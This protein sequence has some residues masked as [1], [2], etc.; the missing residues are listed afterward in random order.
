[1][2]S[3]RPSL[4][5]PVKTTFDYMQWTLFEQFHWKKWLIWGFLAFLG[6]NAGRSGGFSVPGRYMAGGDD[7]GGPGWDKVQEW[8]VEH[9][10]TLV[11]IGAVAGIVILL[12]GLAWLYIS[13]R[14]RF[15]FLECLIE[16][17]TAIAESWRNN[18][19]LALS[20]FWWFLGYAVFGLL[21]L[22]L[23][24]ISVF[25]AIFRDGHFL[26][27]GEI[28]PK[29]LLVGAGSI[30]IL[31]PIVVIAIYLDDF[32]VPLMWHRRLPVLAAWGVFLDHFRAQPVFFLLY[33]PC[34]WVFSMAAGMI[35][36]LG[37]CLTCCLGA[38]PILGHT[39]FLPVFAFIRM[40]P[41]FV[42][43]QFEPGLQ[44][45]V[46]RPETVSPQPAPN[47]PSGGIPPAPDPAGPEPASPIGG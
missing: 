38:I 7:T 43:G 22:A 19:R 16:N 33:V 42:L 30:L 11:V 25:L 37:M 12:L 3:R 36:L 17:K 2:D 21:L 20:L 27:W 5:T 13:S 23:V 8:I 34:R 35:M 28:W 15:M 9:W 46:Y 47:A 10:Q 44:Q 45:K 1:M 41:V 14:G 31:I 32:I 24:L 26:P 40:Y 6:A 4:F 29:L 39:L 18:G